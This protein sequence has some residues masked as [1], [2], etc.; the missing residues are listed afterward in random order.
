MALR[1][2]LAD[3]GSGAGA[4]GDRRSARCI[5]QTVPVESA[6]LMSSAV[7]LGPADEGSALARRSSEAALWVLVALAVVSPWPFGSVQPWAWGTLTAI[8]LLAVIGVAAH[9][10]LTAGLVL[11][12]LP[13]RGLLGLA[14]LGVVQLLPLPPAIH[15]L[16]APASYAAWHPAHAGAAAV[17]GPGARPIS[18]FPEATLEWLAFA[19][20]LGLLAVLAAPA[21]SRP[22]L[23][24]R[25]CA[26]VI[27]GGVAVAVYGVV[28]RAVFGARL[29]GSIA[30]PTI[31]PFGPFVSKNHFAGYVEMT[32]L[33]AAGLAIGLADRRRAGSTSLDWVRSRRAGAILATFA[34]ALAMGLAVLVSLSR[35][36]ILTLAAGVAALLSVRTALSHRR[37]T[38]LGTMLPGLLALCV[39]AVILAALPDETQQ[40]MRTLSHVTREQSGSFRLDTWRDCVRAVAASPIVGQGLGAFADV[41]PRFKTRWAAFSA[42]HA[43]ND[44]LELLVE[45]GVLGAGLVLAF[46]AQAVPRLLRA[47]RRMQ[48]RVHRGLV[49]GALAAVAAL[50]VHSA[51]DFNLHVPSNAV[52]FAFVASA[53]ASAAGPRRALSPGGALAVAAVAASLALGLA[54]ERSVSVASAYNEARRAAEVLPTGSGGLR[55]TLAEESLKRHLSR[56]PLEPDGW[57]LLAWIHLARGDRAGVRELAAYAATLQPGRGDLAR[58]AERLQRE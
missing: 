6:R 28:A 43:E 58:E 23:A 17:L 8:A 35:G 32:A 15:R 47:L 18:V 21:L 54:R 1:N 7:P 40:R 9:Q 4:P 27:A 55:L 36:G 53:A 22:G 20:G 51:F 11:P 56:R 13:L 37:R 30:V 24:Q 49:T 38:S 12:D 46:L 41:F 2:R 14:L 26:V 48:D 57:L 31:A 19:G 42:H 39:V 29:Y 25:A 10:A 45:G 44:Y 50:L 52:L 34:A 16:V 33:L 5:T 3:I